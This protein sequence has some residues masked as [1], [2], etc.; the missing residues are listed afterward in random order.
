MPISGYVA[1]GVRDL[2]A[3]RLFW[4]EL[5][6]LAPSGAWP[7][8]AGLRH[9]SLEIL[10]DATGEVPAVPGIEIGLRLTRGAF[11]HALARLQG[12]GVMPLRG[13]QDFGG[14]GGLE[15]AVRDPDGIVVTL[16]V[17]RDDAD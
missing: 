1:I 17:P 15:V 12:A 16:F 8:Q 7:K 14:P 6:G 10:L 5:I 9:E 3:S 11:D 2:E 13:P 4:Q